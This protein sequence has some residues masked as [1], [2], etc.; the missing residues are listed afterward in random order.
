MATTTFPFAHNLIGTLPAASWLETI[1][2]DFGLDEM[3]DVDP[4]LC[5]SL[6]TPRAEVKPIALIL[7]AGQTANILTVLAEFV[8]QS[9]MNPETVAI[10]DFLPAIDQLGSATAGCARRWVLDHTNA[11]DQL[12]L[13]ARYTL[14]VTR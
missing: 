6:V 5:L 10:I 8:R 13:I 12:A 11:I 9:V 1:R 7:E 2:R 14:T 4:I 3:D